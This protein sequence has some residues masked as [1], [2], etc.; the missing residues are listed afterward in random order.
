MFL[1]FFRKSIWKSPEHG[2][3]VFEKF[4]FAKNV[5]CNLLV[6]ENIM[7]VKHIEYRLNMK[8]ENFFD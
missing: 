6:I 2:V 5:F 8:A 4:I 7:F 3:K 1:Y